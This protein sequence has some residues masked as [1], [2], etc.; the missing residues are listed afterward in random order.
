MLGIRPSPLTSVILL[1]CVNFI[2]YMDRFTIAGVPDMI[3]TYFNIDSKGL[4]LLQTS[5]IISYMFLSPVFGYFGDRWKRKYIMISGLFIWSMVSL[6]SSFVPS[7]CFGLFLALRCIVGIG[8]A[9]YST[10]APTILTDLFTGNSRTFVL[11]FFYFA[12]PVG[13]GFGYV[14]GS[15]IAHASGNWVWALR[16]TPTLGLFCL[17]AFIVFHTDPPRGLADYA[18]HLH[19]TSWWSDVRILSSNRCFLLLCSGFTG[20]CFVLGAL[21]WFSVDYI[22][23]AIN[24]RGRGNASDYPVALLFG[25]S[26]CLAGLLGVV[27]GS[28]LA[29]RLRAYSGRIDAYI[30]GIGLLLSAPFI[31]AGLISPLYSFYLCLGFVFAGQFLICLNWPLISDMTMSVVIPTRRAT[32][33]AFQML[34]THALGDAISPFVIGIIADAQQTSDSAMSRYLGMQRALFITVFI[35]I[36]SGFLLLCASWYLESAKARVQFIIDASRVE[37]FDVDEAEV[38][39]ERRPLLSN[40]GYSALARPTS[41]VSFAHSNVMVS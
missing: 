15:A 13:S 9:S 11:G 35:C 20:N 24:A 30:S 41:W 17:L 39:A 8:E 25:L 29:R 31:F 12:V 21:A 14:L 19:T 37:H 32:A 1:F 26:A 6:C 3:R 2:N 27:A 16:I 23:D 18:V 4:G 22:Q 33:N 38:E 34:M 28:L 7:N 36:L 10:L 5:F 40:D